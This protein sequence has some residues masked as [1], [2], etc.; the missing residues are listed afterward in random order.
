MTTG[1]SSGTSDTLFQRIEQALGI[2]LSSPLSSEDSGLEKRLHIPSQKFSSRKSAEYARRLEHGA[3]E[4]L[5][6]IDGIEGINK[7][8]GCRLQS[9]SSLLGMAGH[10]GRYIWSRIS[11]QKYL[12]V[13]DYVELQLRNLHQFNQLLEHLIGSGR[14]YLGTSRQ[15]YMDLAAN[16]EQVGIY[17]EQ[18][19]AMHDERQQLHHELEECGAI[20]KGNTQKM[21]YA[22]AH[23]L[24]SVQVQELEHALREYETRQE[25]LKEW[26]SRHTRIEDL[27]RNSIHVW[28]EL[29]AYSVPFEQQVRRLQ[30]IMPHLAAQNK[31]TSALERMLSLFSYYTT[32]LRSRFDAA[33]VHTGQNLAFT[34]DNYDGIKPSLVSF[35]EEDHGA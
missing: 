13:E 20:G 15:E 23:R 12:A 35:A 30:H 32:E 21:Q 27:F 7:E 5:Q 10:I 2:S 18:Y 16:Y 26:L 6:H 29:H 33:L 31:L 28:E 24:L 3:M 17:H 19:R 34:K 11:G 9:H 1:A 25:V 4:L 8:L 14:A 22:K